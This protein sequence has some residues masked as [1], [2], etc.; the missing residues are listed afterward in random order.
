M[1]LQQMKKVDQKRVVQGND[2]ENRKLRKLLVFN[3]L[4]VA[5]FFYNF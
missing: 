3:S 4:H 5:I 2:N 1:I